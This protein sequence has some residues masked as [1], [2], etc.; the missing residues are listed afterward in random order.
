M[1]HESWFRKS[2]FITNHSSQEELLDAFRAR[3]TEEKLELKR[4]LGLDMAE[5]V[6][7]VFN[8]APSVS[9]R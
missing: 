1:A 4:I 9:I 3:E 8:N 6:D 2:V 5:G 7:R